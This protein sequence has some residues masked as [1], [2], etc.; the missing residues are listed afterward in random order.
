MNETTHRNRDAIDLQRLCISWHEQADPE[1]VDSFP[2][3]HFKIPHL[4]PVKI[5]QWLDRTG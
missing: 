1:Q 5:P 4:W 3:G 2:G